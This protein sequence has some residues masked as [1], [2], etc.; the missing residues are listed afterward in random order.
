MRYAWL[1]P[2]VSAVSV[3]VLLLNDHVLKH[4]W[5]GFLTGKLSDVAG[6]VVAPALVALIFLR[7]ADF[8]AVVV[9]GVLFTLVKTTETGAEIASQAWTTLAGP[10][11]VLVDPGDLI[12]LPALGLAWWVRQRSRDRVTARWRVATAVPLAVLAVT[13]TSAWHMPSA[14]VVEL[15]DGAI[16]LDGRYES[17]DGG[18]T[19]TELTG[20]PGATGP[21]RR[22]ACLREHCYRLVDDRVKVMRSA[23]GGRTWATDWEIPPNRVTMLERELVGEQTQEPPIVSSTLVVQERPGGHVVVVANKRD[24]LAVRGIDGAWR[25]IGLTPGG[26]LSESAAIPLDRPGD[27]SDEMLLAGLA[28]VWVSLLGLALQA[29][30]GGIRVIT[31]VGGLGALLMAPLPYERALDGGLPE[32]LALAGGAMLLGAIIAACASVRGLGSR[33][34]GSAI[35]VGVLTGI[36]V[37]APFKAWSAGRLDHG[38]AVAIAAVAAPVVAL[39]GAALLR[40]L[41]GSRTSRPT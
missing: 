22:A 29:R 27:D 17:R 13:A 31:V 11:R 12:A 25:R 33:G 21:G 5:P 14:E 1:C 30:T 40:Y 15:R 9:T 32:L 20:P 41:T 26:G 39:T 3:I 23:D 35:G 10:S 8:A 37:A 28:A 6:L 36:C 4:A 7:R 16:V 38:A 2:P 34:T 18:R 19:W 24:G